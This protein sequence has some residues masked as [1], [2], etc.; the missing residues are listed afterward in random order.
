MAFKG[1]PRAAQYMPPAIPPNMMRSKLTRSRYT[2]LNDK[3]RS[4]PRTTYHRSEKRTP[5]AKC[6]DDRQVGF[7]INM[8]IGVEGIDGEGS[9]Y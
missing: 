1:C 7:E 9:L 6:V 4:F 3:L 5:H 2:P 8:S